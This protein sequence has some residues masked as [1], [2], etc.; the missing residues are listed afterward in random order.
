M[1]RGKCTHRTSSRTEL[2]V[3]LMNEQSNLST[4]KSVS[5]MLQPLVIRYFLP[6]KQLELPPRR[7]PCAAVDPP[8]VV[9]EGR[10]GRKRH[11]WYESSDGIECG[12]VARLVEDVLR[13]SDCV[14]RVRRR[15]AVTSR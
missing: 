9:L 12:L 5:N 15:C 10:E 2:R 3:P 7:P 14:R 11:R 8:E 4:K 6:F 13:H 1:R